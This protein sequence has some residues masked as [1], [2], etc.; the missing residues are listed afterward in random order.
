[1]FIDMD[2]LSGDS[3]FNMED[4]WLKMCQNLFEWYTEAFVKRWPMEKELD[5]LI[6][7]A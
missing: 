6:I 4:L 1:V 7:L 3:K 2:P 5:C